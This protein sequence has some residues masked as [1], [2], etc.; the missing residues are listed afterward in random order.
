MCTP[1]IVH[2]APKAGI[3]FLYVPA[4]EFHDVGTCCK[5]ESKGR[6]ASAARWL[7]F[8]AAQAGRIGALHRLSKPF[9]T[10]A[11]SYPCGHCSYMSFRWTLL[12]FASRPLRVL[13][14]SENFSWCDSLVLNQP[15]EIPQVLLHSVRETRRI[16]NRTDLQGDFRFL[17]RARLERNHA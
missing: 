12:V 9:G 17:L 5:F 7:A 4:Q 10:A 13:P 1:Q 15:F 11:R 14:R 16:E 2:A 6:V 3:D 8:F